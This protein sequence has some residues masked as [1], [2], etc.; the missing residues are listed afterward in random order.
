MAYG[1][2]NQVAPGLVPQFQRQWMAGYLLCYWKERKRTTEAMTEALLSTTEALLG[3]LLP[4][5][6]AQIVQNGAGQGINP[7]QL[8]NVVQQGNLFQADALFTGVRA[9]YQRKVFLGQLGA[10]VCC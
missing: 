10:A 4:A 7:I 9:E 2:L 8:N 3:A 6:Q 1:D 5:I